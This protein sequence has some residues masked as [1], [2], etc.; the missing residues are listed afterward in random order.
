MFTKIRTALG[1][2]YRL[3]LLIPALLMIALAYFDNSLFSQVAFK[4]DGYRYLNRGLLFDFIGF[5]L[6]GLGFFPLFLL[7]HKYQ[8]CL[9]QLIRHFDLKKSR[10]LN[11]LIAAI[12]AVI[13]YFFNM[14][15]IRFQLNN[16]EE[17]WYSHHNPQPNSQWSEV[18]TNAGYVLFVLV[19]LYWAL[20]FYMFITSIIYLSYLSYLLLLTSFL[21]NHTISNDQKL[22]ITSYLNRSGLVIFFIFGFFILLT[23]FDFSV[24]GMVTFSLNYDKFY[25]LL[26]LIGLITL[27]TIFNNLIGN[28]LK[29][30]NHDLPDYNSY[31]FKNLSWLELILIGFIFI[32]F[33]FFGFLIYNLIGDLPENNQALIIYS[34]LFLS[35]VF[36]VTYRLLKRKY[37][38]YISTV[39]S[40][41][42][43]IEDYNLSLEN[44]FN[45]MR[46]YKHDINNIL[47]S[48]AGY[49]EEKKYQDLE[50]FFYTEIMQTNP[51]NQKSYHIIAQI[52]AIN[53][54]LIKNLIIAKSSQIVAHEINLVIDCD[55]AIQNLPIKDSDFSRVF[56][57][58][59]D[60]AIEASSLSEQKLV[61]IS[62]AKLDNQIHLKIINTYQYQA[63][64][65]A[66]TL[67][68]LNFSTKSASRGLGLYSLKLTLRHYA[69]IQLETKIEA[70]YFLQ[71]LIFEN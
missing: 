71:K 17:M 29:Q 30:S 26:L 6:Q 31:F 69:R 19:I 20:V 18:F 63:A 14:I 37:L 62:L 35:A 65:S 49:I 42:R 5:F 16:G 32:V 55:S 47:L 38:T 41:N 28:S 4:D 66:D 2:K 33:I 25:Y 60:N 68:E 50:D 8:T 21:K 9:H 39:N 44:L 45:E 22:A 12:A 46:I 57:I 61:E 3:L 40:L 13:S 11:P 70:N 64:L 54:R 48:L 58:L 43:H 7:Y 67:N 59:I 1:T 51:G 56:G 53:H 27:H 23:L 24:M 34:L 10:Y 36:I 52:S 15:W